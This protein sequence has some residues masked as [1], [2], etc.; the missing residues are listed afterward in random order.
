MT[1]RELWVK[2]MKTVGAMVGGT[3]V[4]LG[5]MS[6]VLLLIGGGHAA[7]TSEARTGSTGTAM[8]SEA[9]GS[10]ALPPPRAQRHGPKSESRA[11]ESRPGDSI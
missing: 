1:D 2:T 5:S 8:S 10:E 7:P 6:L 9:K 3:V 4:F 11:T